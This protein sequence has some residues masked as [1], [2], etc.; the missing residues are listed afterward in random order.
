MQSVAISRLPQRGRARVVTKRVWHGEGDGGVTDSGSGAEGAGPDHWGSI[1]RLAGVVG[2]DP[3]SLT[4]RELVA[5]ADARQATEWERA[6]EIIANQINVA[7]RKNVVS[8]KQ[9]NPYRR[10]QTRMQPPTLDDLADFL[11]V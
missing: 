11:E 6:A 2:F 8:A 1:A 4:L 5:A 3:G 10:A 7:A 9:I